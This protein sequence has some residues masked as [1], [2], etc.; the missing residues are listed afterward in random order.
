[1]PPNLSISHKVHSQHRRIP[2]AITAVFPPSGNTLADVANNGSYLSLSN[3]KLYRW[4]LVVGADNDTFATGL[5]GIREVAITGTRAKINYDTHYSL[6]GASGDCSVV[7]VS[8]AGVVTFSVG[9][10][11]VLDLLVWAN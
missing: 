7:G 9:G 11:V 2:L 4:S 10:A 8:A 5:S 3:A 1:M 6:V